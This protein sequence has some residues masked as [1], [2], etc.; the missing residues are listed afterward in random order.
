MG[1]P[2][3]RVHTRDPNTQKPKTGETQVQDQ[4]GPCSETLLLLLFK[5]KKTTTTK[6]S[7]QEIGE[8]AWR[9]FWKVGVQAGQM[10]DAEA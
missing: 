10:A 7:H 5:K 3:W 2:G 1:L 8:S 6:S 4:R 9:H